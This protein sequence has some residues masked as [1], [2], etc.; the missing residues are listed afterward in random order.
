MCV[1]FIMSHLSKL[2]SHSA[3]F[4]T[5]IISFFMTLQVAGLY[6]VL[7]STTLDKSSIFYF[8]KNSIIKIGC[9]IFVY[10]VRRTVSLLL[11]SDICLLSQFIFS[12]FFLTDFFQNTFSYQILHNLYTMFF[13]TFSESQF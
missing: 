2:N 12:T 4:G 13:Q 3:E 8:F 9:H 11:M 1:Y 6:R 10:D 5:N 7:S